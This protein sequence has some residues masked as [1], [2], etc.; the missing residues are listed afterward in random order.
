MGLE[1]LANQYEE[2]INFNLELINSGKSRLSY[3]VSGDCSKGYIKEIVSPQTTNANGGSI[4]YITF[5]YWSG[6]Q[7][8]VKDKPSTLTS[9]PPQK[10]TKRH[11]GKHSE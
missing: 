7:D 11:K 2:E 3:L 5:L 9:H 1:P 4:D 10:I 8:I 6:V